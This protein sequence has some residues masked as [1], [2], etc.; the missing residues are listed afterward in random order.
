LAGFCDAVI[1]FRVPINARNILDYLRNCQL[2]KK[3]S[4][5]CSYLF[6]SLVSSFQRSAEYKQSLQI[7]ESLTVGHYPD[8][9]VWNL[10]PHT[11]S[12]TTSDFRHKADENCA[13]LGHYTVSSDNSLPTFRDK[14]SVP[15][16]MG[17]NLTKILEPC[18]RN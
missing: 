12:R 18:K 3:D 7:P 9:K 2:L 11:L 5:P 15:S 13:V 16:S 14:L 4:A 1:N 6:I 8:L 17:K 10:K